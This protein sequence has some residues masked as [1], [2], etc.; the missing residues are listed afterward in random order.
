MVS[1]GDEI[2]RKDLLI[3]FITGVIRNR[4]LKPVLIRFF[5][6]N[7][8]ILSK[9]DQCS[10]IKALYELVYQICYEMLKNFNCSDEL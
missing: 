2:G 5:G 6:I 7:Q 1:N 9:V 4:R 10:M 8:E 3:S